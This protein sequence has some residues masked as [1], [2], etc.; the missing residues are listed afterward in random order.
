MAR[1]SGRSDATVDGAEA[2]GRRAWLAFLG[3]PPL[4]VVSRA[5]A[6]CR[7][8]EAGARRRGFGALLD[9]DSARAAYA[10]AL[11]TRPAAVLSD[12]RLSDGGDEQLRVAV[13]SDFL[14]RE[15]PLIVVPLA[16]LARREADA[17]RLG[18]PLFE[19]LDSVLSPRGALLNELARGTPEVTGWVEPIGVANLLRAIGAGGGA[20]TLTLDPEQGPAVAVTIAGGRGRARRGQ[21]CAGRRSGAGAGRPRGSSLALLRL[22]ARAGRQGRVTAAAFGAGR[23][24]NRAGAAPEQRAGPSH[25]R[26]RP[27]A[28]GLGG[29]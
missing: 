26:A 18:E 2:G 13:R 27:R 4:L 17:V 11:K 9:T 21:R 16:D 24:G 6:A 7:A 25:L 8:L 14:L 29:R 23:G 10:M 12:T 28:G 5:G 22:H 15:V 1:P 3:A 19:A 20:G